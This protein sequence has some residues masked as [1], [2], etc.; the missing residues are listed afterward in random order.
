MIDFF[1]PGIPRPAGSKRALPTKSGKIAIVDASGQKGKDWRAD[2]KSFAREVYRGDPVVGPLYLGIIFTMIR[3]KGHYGTGRNA[4][5]LKG[6]AP[7]YPTG[8]PD[9]TKLIRGL[10]D[11]LTGI[12]WRDDAQI[13][14]QTVVKEYGKIP[15]AYISVRRLKREERDGEKG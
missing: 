2:C 14:K 8:K 10:E 3:P 7:E 15:G 12:V 5:K 4:E 11:A 13:V 9:L 1:V 6:S